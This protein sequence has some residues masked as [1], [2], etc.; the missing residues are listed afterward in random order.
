VSEVRRDEER[1]ARL[2]SFKARLVDGPVLVLPLKNSNYQFNP[3]TLTPLDGYGTIYP[4]MRLTDDWGALEVE[5]GGALVRDD[6]SKATVLAKGADI[7]QL[8]GDGWRL[9]LNP[10]WTIQPGARKGDFTVARPSSSEGAT[11]H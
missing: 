2:A 3:Q 5:N 9:S 10:G 8:K 1:H 7:A 6:A 11:P 4:T